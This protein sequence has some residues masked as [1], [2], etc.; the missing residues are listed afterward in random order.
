MTG[1][2]YT[3]GH[4]N[5]ALEAFVGLLRKHGIQVLVDV[6]SQPA[7]RY[8]PH[9]NKNEVAAGVEAAGVRYLFL[10]AELGG[11]PEG[12]D[13]YDEAG[14]VLYDRLAASPRF[15]EGIVRLER[16]LTRFRV[17]IMCSEEDPAVCHRYLLI[18]RVMRES[19]VPIAHIRGDGS[20]QDDAELQPCR[21][22]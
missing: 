14:H 20:L 11:R 17:A 6:R 7:S 16:G 8:L 15:Q 18:A 3:V 5:H 12:R 2:L 4:S 9:F 13:F 1:A 21:R 22:L 10:G 19:G